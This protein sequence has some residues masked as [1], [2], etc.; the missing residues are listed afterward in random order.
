MELPIN[1]V[2]INH[3]WPVLVFL[4]YWVQI[5]LKE[6]Y[7]YMIYKKGEFFLMYPISGSIQQSFSHTYHMIIWQ[8]DNLLHLLRLVISKQINNYHENISAEEWLVISKSI[9]Y[10]KYKA[11][12]FQFDNLILLRGTE[13][14]TVDSKCTCILK[15][16]QVKQR[17][18]KIK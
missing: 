12:I 17:M 1:H 2:Q 5:G 16:Y 10:A 13:L 4:C 6:S 18:L 9:S 11:D 7:G 3:A 14:V 15:S 8:F